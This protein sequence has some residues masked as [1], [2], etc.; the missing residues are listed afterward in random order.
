MWP[1]D[2]HRLADGHAR[3]RVVG[4]VESA[5]GV[6]EF[7]VASGEVE[8]RKLEAETAGN[9]QAKWA[10]ARAEPHRLE[11]ILAD[12]RDGTTRNQVSALVADLARSAALDQLPPVSLALLGEGLLRGG[13]AAAAEKVLRPAQRQY[14]RDLALSLALAQALEVLSRRPEAIRYYIM[15]RAIRPESA[16]DLAHAH[17]QQSETDEAIAVDRDLIRFSPTS[18]L[19]YSCLGTV[20][21]SRG[22]TDEANLV[23]DAGITAGRE[24]VRLRPGDP[25]AHLVLGAAMTQRGKLD[26]G[27]AECREAIRLRPDDAS[28]HRNL[29]V[30]RQQQGALDDAIV[31]LRESEMTTAGKDRLFEALRASLVSSSEKVPYAQIAVA[32]GCSERAARDAAHRLRAR[33][34]A[35]LREEVART[36]VDSSTV[37]EEIRDLFATFSD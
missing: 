9:D 27:V 13:D 34:R 29:G 22:L 35:L 12:A 36:I 16:H 18:S 11:Q 6:T 33:Y 3:G 8:L 17:E 14:P 5:T 23:L 19:N 28:A 20:L 7:D 24:A 26:E 2:G 15:A 30:A 32:L 4:G 31:E 21:R 37:E 1:G 10:T 25:F